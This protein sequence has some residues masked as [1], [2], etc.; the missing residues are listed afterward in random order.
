MASSDIPVTSPAVPPEGEYWQRLAAPV[1]S[2]PRGRAE[3]QERRRAIREAVR[4]MLGLA[5]APERLPLAPE[6]APAASVPAIALE[7]IGFQIWPRVSATGWL[8]RPA[9]AGA[10]PALLLVLREPW[11]SVTGSEQQELIRAARSGFV[12]LA[13]NGA[14]LDRP[15]LGLST[16][17]VLTW[18]HLRAVEYLLTRADVDRARLG[19]L[20]WGAGATLAASVIALE[21]R[22]AA[23]AVA[24]PVRYLGERLPHEAAEL[25]LVAPPGLLGVAD[26]PEMLASLAPRPLLV[27]G[28]GEGALGDLHNVYGLYQLQ[29]RL[30]EAAAPEAGEDSF[31]G[32]LAW[33][34][35]ALGG[36]EAAGEVR[37]G[38][39]RTGSH[40]ANP[41]AAPSDWSAIT[42]YLLSRAVEPPRL[43]SR[44]AKKNYQARLRGELRQL[45]RDPEGEV[46]L[47]P[48]SM[49][50][51]AR[52]QSE[53]G[54]R[55]A[56][57]FYP[58]NGE[59][60][61][62]LLLIG[63]S[64]EREPAL[65]EACRG[66][67]VA[68]A[69]LDSRLALSSAPGWP[70]LLRL[71]GRPA[72]GL[73]ARDA[74][75]AVDWLARRRD[76]DTRRIAI[77]GLAEAGVVALLTA[78]WDERIG[79]VIADCCGTTY[80]DGGEGLP[81]LPGILQVAD[82]PQL[83]SLSAPRPLWL[84]RVPAE[85]AGFSSRRYY[86]WTRRTYQSLGAEE[87]LRMDTGALP[88][89]VDMMRWLQ[90]IFKR[91]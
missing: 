38:A 63:P 8:A 16:A 67:G 29:Q 81:L 42:N 3:W 52:F 72:A 71:T 19:L 32:P 14:R 74:I 76:V 33:L 87:A 27:A 89:A 64:A 60:A 88:G 82:V 36:R 7:R 91:R 11:S 30:T 65:R 78:G 40:A 9:E 20:A 17:G 61:P 83:A 2:N 48:R 24:E 25:D 6:C 55:V 37:V 62:V 58:T 70:S 90:Q 47:C 49:E 69:A 59:R 57:R 79:A 1:S 43:E 51:G 35:G 75:A 77:A 66:A 85:R 13:L 12:A 54:A 10:H 68:L 56:L 21:E 45:V 18:N 44:P 80:R 5:A 4:Q 50:G 86:D 15:E 23:A 41:P 28:G 53:P 73:A 84:A 26:L 22:F 46:A 31:A 34:A 39:V